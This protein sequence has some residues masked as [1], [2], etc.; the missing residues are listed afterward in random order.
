MERIPTTLNTIV[1]YA[2][3]RF[4]KCFLLFSSKLLGFIGVQG[5]QI[6]KHGAQL[7]CILQNGENDKLENDIIKVNDRCKYGQQ[8]QDHR[9]GRLQ[10]F[11][12]G[13]RYFCHFILYIVEKLA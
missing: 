10:L 2:E 7:L 12:G 9:C 3:A 13:P 11:L 8:H 5:Q 6:V 1:E 4:I